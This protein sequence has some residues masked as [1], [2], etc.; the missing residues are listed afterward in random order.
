MLAVAPL[1]VS[2][3]FGRTMRTAVGASV[4][5]VSV[6]M[7]VKGPTLSFRGSPA[8]VTIGDVGT[9]RAEVRGI[10]ISP[11]ATARSVSARS[12]PRSAKMNTDKHIDI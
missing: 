5:W 6:S 9:T 10:G 8:D 7:W 1:A 4:S 12:T 3:A 11:V 2:R